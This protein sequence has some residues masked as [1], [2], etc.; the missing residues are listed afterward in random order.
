MYPSA[1]GE[2]WD[3]DEYDPLSEAEE[4]SVA[5]DEADVPADDHS[6]AA[7]YAAMSMLDS[8]SE[9]V[10]FDRERHPVD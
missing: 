5:V 7:M 8:R 2:R 4:E 10:I 9:T 6:L 3:D 1:P